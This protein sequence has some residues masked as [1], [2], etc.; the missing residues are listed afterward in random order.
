V[1]GFVAGLWAVTRPAGAGGPAVLTVRPFRSFSA[2]HEAQLRREVAS[3]AEFA[4]RG[5]PA[6]VVVEPPA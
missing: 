2:R 4:A 6:Q 3:L 5:G 1:D